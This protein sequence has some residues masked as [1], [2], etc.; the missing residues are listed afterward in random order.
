M[1]K[2]VRIQNGVSRPPARAQPTLKSNKNIKRFKHHTYI[3]PN[4]PLKQFMCFIHAFDLNLSISLMAFCSRRIAASNRIRHHCI[5]MFE[6][7]VLVFV[8]F[9]F[10]RTTFSHQI[11]LLPPNASASTAT[12]QRRRA[13]QFGQAFGWCGHHRRVVRGHLL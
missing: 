11:L 2:N 8:L 12:H 7:F 13:E 3:T 5:Y 9:F 1:I 6:C 4:H 10:W